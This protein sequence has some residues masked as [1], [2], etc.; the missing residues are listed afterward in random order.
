MVKNS[1]YTRAT[2]YKNNNVVSPVPTTENQKIKS[3]IE[4]Y[5]TV[6]YYY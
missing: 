4:W 2:S 6:Q 5:D 3:V 1:N